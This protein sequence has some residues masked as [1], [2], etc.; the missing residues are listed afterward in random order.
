MKKVT[1]A[2]FASPAA[3]TSAIYALRSAGI[4]H[5]D[6][7]LVTSDRVDRDAFTVES[8]SKLTEGAG[9]GAAAGGAVGALVAG[10][11][12]VGTIATGGAGLLVAGPIVAAF[13]GAGAGAAAGATLGAIAGFAVPEHE[14]KYY[15]DAI[16][17][18]SVLI[19]IEC[20]DAARR[21]RVVEI[22]EDSGALKVSSI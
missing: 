14:V 11:T 4:A 10:L 2:L 15:E 7:S 21:E 1:T 6:I 20:E 16:K 5:H 13:A 8:H 17:K 12:A 18:G 3:A 19:G 9:I 22:C